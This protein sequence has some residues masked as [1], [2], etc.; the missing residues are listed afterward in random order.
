MLDLLQKHV[1]FLKIKKFLKKY[2]T[3]NYITKNMS[4]ILH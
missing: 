4:F 1:C 2:E 3:Y